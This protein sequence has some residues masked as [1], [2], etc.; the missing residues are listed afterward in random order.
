MD[1]TQENS[2][3]FIFFFYIL[4]EAEWRSGQ[5]SRL[6]IWWSRVQVPL[7]PL[8]GFDLGSPWLNSLAALVY[9]QLV[10]LLPVGIL[11]TC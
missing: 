7:W 2:F 8:A 11:I 6:E 4:L 5:G 3:S 10:C 1:E 9:S